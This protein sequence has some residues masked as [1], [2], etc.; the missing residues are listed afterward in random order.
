M[1]GYT[2]IMKPHDR[3]AEVNDDAESLVD[4]LD[5]IAAQPLHERVHGFEQLHD[6]LVAELQ[7]GDR[8]TE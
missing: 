4:R 3:T 5:L 2:G 7:R 1:S 8:E 6:E